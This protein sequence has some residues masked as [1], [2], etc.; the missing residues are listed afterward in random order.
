MEKMIK[1]LSN[2]SERF[3]KKKEHADKNGGLSLAT[4]LAYGGA[5]F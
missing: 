5:Y 2:K 1:I 3:I 4:G